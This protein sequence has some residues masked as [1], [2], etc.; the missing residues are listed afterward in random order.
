MPRGAQGNGC[1]EVWRGAWL[2]PLTEYPQLHSGFASSCSIPTGGH[3][4]DT[5]KLFT[6]GHSAHTAFTSKGMAGKSPLGAGSWK[7]AEG[8]RK[9]GVGVG[10]GPER[11]WDRGTWISEWG[12][13]P[14]TLWVP[15][16]ATL[17]NLSPQGPGQL[18][19]TPCLQR[20]FPGSCQILSRLPP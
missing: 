19:R 4:L 16:E 5:Q 3:F 1:Q 8:P 2:C 14:F 13:L 12:S 9:A 18:T 17:S 7:G 10:R 11:G 20:N 6:H 15:R